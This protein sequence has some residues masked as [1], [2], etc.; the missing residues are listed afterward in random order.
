MELTQPTI[1]PND[2]P[3]PWYSFNLERDQQ[4][5]KIMEVS[6]IVRIEFRILTDFCTNEDL[7]QLSILLRRMPDLHQVLFNVVLQPDN[8]PAGNLIQRLAPLLMY[9]HEIFEVGIVN[10][11]PTV[12][13][14]L[15]KC[16]P[17][18]QSMFIA[19]SKLSAV[20]WFYSR[21]LQRIM[22]FM[23]YDIDA[24]NF[25][26]RAHLINTDFITFSTNNHNDFLNM[27]SIF[28]NNANLVN[29]ELSY[30]RLKCYHSD[31]SE[32]T[33]M[34]RP[35]ND[36]SQIWTSNLSRMNQ[37]LIPILNVQE[38]YFRNF[39]NSIYLSEYTGNVQCEELKSFFK[40]FKVLS[41]IQIDV[42]GM[43]AANTMSELW[44]TM[45]HWFHA[46]GRTF[47]KIQ[48]Q[49]Q[50]IDKK[51]KIV[52]D[53]DDF[54][55]LNIVGEFRSGCVYDIGFLD[56][57]IIKLLFENVTNYVAEEYAQILVR[58][59]KATKLVLDDASR[60]IFGIIHKTVEKEAPWP[61][62]QELTLDYD[63]RLFKFNFVFYANP[64]LDLN[65]FTKNDEAND[66]AS[67]RANAVQCVATKSLYRDAINCFYSSAAPDSPPS[68]KSSDKSP[69]IYT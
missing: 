31:N 7:I 66:L 43:D 68:A 32:T 57:S 69:A 48:T 20:L 15:G 39:V 11:E 25:M 22:V 53:C 45:S 65:F 23:C 16:F 56:A 55:N 40:S 35:R 44:L 27:H 64:G 61:S 21:P 67:F 24:M 37:L 5:I 59:D 4:L 30:I 14:D 33:Y 8:K 54:H 6:E 41:R 38:D 17:K 26:H 49:R 34:N 13:I 3:L 19:H 12:P 47:L 42:G 60:K 63:V 9:Q 50:N 28:S 2:N 18:A 58:L 1:D 29:S 62:L 51:D 52:I 46:I 10:Y 36:Y